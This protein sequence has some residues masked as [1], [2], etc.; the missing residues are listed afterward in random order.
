MN[1]PIIKNVNQKDDLDPLLKAEKKEQKLKQKQLEFYFTEISQIHIYLY[2]NIPDKKPVLLERKMF[3]TNFERPKTARK[4]K[5][6]SE[7]PFFTNDVEYNTKSLYKL[8]PY[9][10]FDFFFNRDF[11]EFKLNEIQR[12]SGKIPEPADKE[13]KNKYNHKNIMTMLHLLFSTIYPRTNNVTSTFYELIQNKS[14]SIN[15]NRILSKNEYTYMKLD[16][17]EYTVMKAVWL[18]DLFNHPKYNNLAIEYYKYKYWCETQSNNIKNEIKTNKKKINDTIKGFEFDEFLYIIENSLESAKNNKSRLYETNRSTQDFFNLQTFRNIFQILYL[19][20]QFLKDNSEENFIEN[21]IKY[22][23]GFKPR[24]GMQVEIKLPNKS[25]SID[26]NEYWYYGKIMQKID[27]SKELSKYKVQMFYKKINNEI[28]VKNLTI[29]EKNIREPL[30][31]KITESD[32]KNYLKNHNI[33]IKEIKISNDYKNEDSDDTFIKYITVPNDNSETND[34][35]EFNKNTFDENNMYYCYKFIN[36]NEDI[37]AEIKNKYDRKT[38]NPNKILF[39]NLDILEETFNRIKN[40]LTSINTYQKT[41]IDSMI[42]IYKTISPKILFDEQ[43]L[44]HSNIDI[45]NTSINIKEYNDFVKFIKEYLSPIYNT[46]N[47]KL[48]NY[49]FTYAENIASQNF[50]TF[51]D[52]FATCFSNTNANCD[53]IKHPNKKEFLNLINIDL[54]YININNKEKPQYEMNLFLNLVEGRVDKNNLS[55][56]KCKYNDEYLTNKFEN[57]VQSK[58]KSWVFQPGPLMSVSPKSAKKTVKN[59]GGGKPRH[60]TLKNRQKKGKI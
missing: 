11:F 13:Q 57:L 10:I 14:N 56:I 15:L 33:E 48:Q 6:Y 27:T 43:Y 41:F 52:L 54:N 9:E 20:K 8:E 25:D 28:G 29:E 23:T 42:K 59:Q 35:K 18:N 55:T 49:I 21:V 7:I 22:G 3:L 46:S 2:T 12:K 4:L 58:N 16:N 19:Y 47:S 24:V 53:I 50:T 5:Q 51:M 45:Q 60:K 31:D 40:N 34:L 37:E 17:R 26:E 1:N 44:T 30:I 36:K 38:N 39:K 32:I